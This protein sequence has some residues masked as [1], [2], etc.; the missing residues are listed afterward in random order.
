[1]HTEGVN[2]LE[3]PATP[4]KLRQ[5]AKRGVLKPKDLEQALKLI[6][7]TP[8]PSRWAR[9]LE[10]V[11]LVLGVGFIVSGVFFFF[12]FNWADMHRFLK[13]GVL[14]MAVLLTVGLTVWQKLDRLPG[15]IA[16]SATGLL[17]GALLA[18]F[19]Q[20]YQTGADAYQLFLT[21]ALLISGWVLISQF[22]PLWFIWIL[23]LNLSV[24]FYG[25]QIVGIHGQLYLWL[26]LLNGGAILIWEFANRRGV[27]WLKSRWTPRLLALPTFAALVTPTRSFVSQYSLNSDRWLFL[28]AIL[29]ILFSALVLYSYSQKT[30]DLF[31]LIVCSFSLM[32]VFNA[33]LFNVLGFQTT[34]LFWISAAIIGQATLIVTWL[35]NV[36]KAW[37]VRNPWNLN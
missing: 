36:S 22:A 16:L 18:V 15:K 8:S 10:I 4:Q 20:I 29:F 6:G 21:W 34:T 24:L 12:A 37:E 23:L 3:L 11:L 30:L 33:W 17:V 9:F 32:I 5:L 13:L 35:R 7:H 27:N 28:M 26:S 1:M 2:P 19:G 25:Q 14:E 31:M